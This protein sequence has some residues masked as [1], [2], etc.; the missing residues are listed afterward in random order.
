VNVVVSGATQVPPSY[1]PEALV[2]RHNGTPSQYYQLKFEDVPG[3]FFAQEIRLYIWQKDTSSSLFQYT[4]DYKDSTTA[5]ST[6][7]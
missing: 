3:S 6:A 5:T 4:I 2:M 7:E 1:I